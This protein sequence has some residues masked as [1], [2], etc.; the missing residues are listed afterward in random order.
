[1]FLSAITSAP[2]P[3]TAVGSASRNQKISRLSEAHLNKGIPLSRN[4]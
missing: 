2:L 3:L 1:M 4:A